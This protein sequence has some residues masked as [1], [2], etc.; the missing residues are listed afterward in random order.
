MTLHTSIIDLDSIQAD[1]EAASF[2]P[3]ARQAEI[4]ALAHTII[5]LKGLVRIPAVR[6]LKID[7]Y[8]LVSGWL[9]YYAFLKAKE[10]DSDLPD[11]ITVFILQPSNEKMILKQLEVVQEVDQ[12]LASNSQDHPSPSDDLLALRISNLESS[13][14]KNS[15][16]LESSLKESSKDVNSAIEQLKSEM[17]A[18]IDSKLPQFLPPLEAFNRI[19]EPE[20]HEQVIRKLAFLGKK[21][22]EKLIKQIQSHQKQHRTEFKHFND[23]LQILEKGTL[24]PEKMLEII[25]TWGTK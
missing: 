23:I 16:Y 21:K 2:D 12:L 7:E 5:E 4:E 3:D 18:T 19:L 17:L 14:R 10:L 1:S 8:E 25:D 9:E 24:S 13:L 6:E 20:I 11:R 22:A 15:E